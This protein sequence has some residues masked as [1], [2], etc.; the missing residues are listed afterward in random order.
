MLVMFI[1]AFFVVMWKITVPGE[2]LQ[3]LEEMV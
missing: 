1:V 3:F 2:D